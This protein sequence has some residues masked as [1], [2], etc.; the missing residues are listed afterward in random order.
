MLRWRGYQWRWSN[1]P[2]PEQYVAGLLG[3]LVLQLYRPWRAF[4]TP[5]VPRAASAGLVGSGL[6]L[7]GW[8][9]RTVGEQPIEVPSTLVTTGPYAIS[10]NPM[11]VAWTA[12]YVGVALLANTMWLFVAFPVVVTTTH[13]LV[14]REEQSLESTFGDEYRA[15]Q[16]AVPRYL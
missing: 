7:V 12:L 6:L 14:R 16:R 8:A 3:G 2:I 15:Y 11:Y 10:R 9:V 1:V 5:W 13:W 4:A